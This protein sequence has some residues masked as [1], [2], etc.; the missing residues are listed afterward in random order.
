[1]ILVGELSIWVA[2]LMAAWGS[3]VSFAGGRQRRVDLVASGERAVLAAC[4]FTGVAT[5]GV[6]YG[7][8]T[9]DLSLR[10]VAESTSRNLPTLYAL[11][12]L[13]VGDAGAFLAWAFAL[14]GWSA[15]AVHRWRRH[16][17][18]MPYATGTLALCTLALL[19]LSVD[20][21][22]PFARLDWAAGDGL[23]MHPALQQPAMLLHR[24]FFALGGTVTAIPLALTVSALLTGTPSTIARARVQPWIALAWV[25]LTASLVCGLWWAYEDVALPGLWVWHPLRAGTLLP[26]VTCTILLH[27]LSHSR[28][29][30]RWPAVNAGLMVLASMLSWVG[31]VI[32]PGGG[33]ASIDE[34]FTGGTAL[35]CTA[36]A[37]GFAWYVARSTWAAEE[38]SSSARGRSRESQLGLQL[39]YAGAAIAVIG[40][41]GSAFRSE[42]SQVPLAVGETHTATDPWGT[43]WSFSSDGVS[44]YEALNRNVTALSLRV[45]RGNSPAGSLLAEQRQYIDSFRNPTFE[46]TTEAAVRSTIVGDV[47]VFVTSLVD[48]QTAIVQIRFYPLVLWVWIGAGLLLVG[49]IVALWPLPMRDR[50]SFNP[51]HVE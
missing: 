51:S 8:V 25:L 32:R 35:V 13:W 33:V 4:V 10:I 11:G 5:V 6:A 20:P 50:T 38:S 40:L 36:L 49:G 30:V 9:S 16:Y 23:G 41:L 31:L 34:L 14:S 45:A 15:L 42:E 1:M 43:E 18:S 29:D 39:A 2:I 27:T 28:R 19:A 22:S 21:V 17:G 7:L 44:N 24:L 26:W 47:Y 46:P 37:T 48:A 3:L 12:A